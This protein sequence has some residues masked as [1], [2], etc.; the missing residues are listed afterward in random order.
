MEPSGRNRWQME[1]PRKPLKQV[2]PHPAATHGNGSGA[3]GK[4]G[5]GGPAAAQGWVAGIARNPPLLNRRLRQP[6][7]ATTDWSCC[8]LTKA[9]VTL[10]RLESKPIIWKPLKTLWYLLK[11]S[12]PDAPW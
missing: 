12:F 4:E 3:H 2:D 5:V 9:R 1:H 8:G 11:S 6:P 7:L 10:L